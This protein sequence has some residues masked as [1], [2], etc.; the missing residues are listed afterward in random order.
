MYFLKATRTSFLAF[1]LLF[2]FS[3]AS[4]SQVVFETTVQKRWPGTYVTGG[5]YFKSKRGK[6]GIIVA[7]EAFGFDDRNCYGGPQ[8]I[9]RCNRPTTLYFTDHFQVPGLRF[10]QST[11][12]R[13]AWVFRNSQKNIVCAK[14]T[15]WSLK[16]TGYCSIEID[17]S[18]SDY[19]VRFVIR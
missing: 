8:D 17:E 11:G 10:S 1:A 7:S 2:G 18:E 6:S 13:G 14:K 16:E 3:F 4:A 19:S 12:K 15:F 5:S 9:P